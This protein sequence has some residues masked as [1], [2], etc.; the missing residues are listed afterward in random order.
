[1]GFTWDLLRAP[2][3]NPRDLLWEECDGEHRLPRVHTEKASLVSATLATER[4]GGDGFNRRLSKDVGRGTLHSMQHPKT[5]TTL[6]I[7]K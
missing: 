6:G 2:K 1:M 5:L 7:N 3:V 4:A